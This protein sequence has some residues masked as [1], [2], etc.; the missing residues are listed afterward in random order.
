MIRL[1]YRSSAGVLACELKGLPALF[2]KTDSETLTQLAGED[3]RAAASRPPESARAGAL[4]SVPLTLKFEIPIDAAVFLRD[5]SIN[6]VVRNF[7]ERFVRTP[8]FQ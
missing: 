6:L 8:G 2:R 1:A 5:E 4:K 3:A 7:V